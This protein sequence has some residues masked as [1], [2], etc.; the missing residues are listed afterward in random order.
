MGNKRK[1]HEKSIEDLL[2]MVVVNEDLRK[3]VDSRLLYDIKNRNT[4]TVSQAKRLLALYQ[5]EILEIKDEFL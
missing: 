1:L 3:K 4:R 5:A 2:D